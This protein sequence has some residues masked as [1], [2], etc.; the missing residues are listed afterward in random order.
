MWGDGVRDT[1]APAA[2]RPGPGLAP[3]A[4]SLTAAKSHRAPQ[5]CSSTMGCVA[6]N[7][8]PSFSVPQFP[9]L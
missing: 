9:H 3:P 4:V 6:F 5:S 2:R 7:R 1:Q 8:L